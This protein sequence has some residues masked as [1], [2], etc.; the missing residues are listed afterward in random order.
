[1]FFFQMQKAQMEEAFIH[2]EQ[3]EG[4]KNKCLNL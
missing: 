1:M 4:A 3:S 2:T